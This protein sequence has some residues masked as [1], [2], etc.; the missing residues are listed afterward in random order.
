MAGAEK[1]EHG[2]GNLSVARCES[3]TAWSEISRRDFEEP[4]SLAP[5]KLCRELLLL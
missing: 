4:Q 1:E 2:R 5:L 3:H